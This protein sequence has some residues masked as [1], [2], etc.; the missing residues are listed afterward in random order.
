MTY[1]IVQV[2][3]FASWNCI[4]WEVFFRIWDASNFLV[5]FIFQDSGEMDASC[6]HLYI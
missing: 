4:S 5:R 1:L 2:L 6:L 3:F